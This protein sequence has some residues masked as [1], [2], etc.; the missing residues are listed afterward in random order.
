M[1]GCNDEKFQLQKQINTVG[2]II[3]KEAP[4]NS[5]AFFNKFSGVLWQ[6]HYHNISKLNHVAMIL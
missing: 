5:G 3:K 2:I 6:I 1:I 4:K